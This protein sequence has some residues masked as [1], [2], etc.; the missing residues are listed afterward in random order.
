MLSSVAA[1]VLSIFRKPEAGPSPALA[2]VATSNE[3]SQTDFRDLLRRRLH[4]EAIPV[5]LASQQPEK[6]LR[7]MRLLNRQ[8]LLRVLIADDRTIRRHLSNAERIR[9][10]IPCSWEDIIEHEKWRA[11][12]ARR[13]LLGGDDRGGGGGPKR[14][15]ASAPGGM[16]GRK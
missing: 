3:P 8:M 2:Q 12:E 4:N 9:R 16:G 15:K 7:W 11:M 14:P 10:V 6:V 5:A 13:Q 1:A